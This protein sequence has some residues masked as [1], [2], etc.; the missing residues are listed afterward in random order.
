FFVPYS[1]PYIIKLILLLAVLALFGYGVYRLFRMERNFTVAV[2]VYELLFLVAKGY[3]DTTRPDIEFRRIFSGLWI[4]YLICFIGGYF[5]LA[6]I[7]HRQKIKTADFVTGGG[8]LLVLSVSLGIPGL[9]I[10]ALVL[11]LV[12][13]VFTAFKDI[14]FSRKL[15]YPAVLIL[16]IFIGQVFYFSY[17]KSKEY[18]VSMAPKAAYAAAQWLNLARIKRGA[19]ILSY[20]DNVMMNFYLD[21]NKEGLQEI[22][23][24]TFTVPLIIN[25]ETKAHYIQAFF[26]EIRE[27]K[28]DYIIF[29][30]YVVPKPEFTGVNQAKRMLYEERENK[31]YF[32]LKQ[33]LFYKGEN[34]G[35]VLKPVNAETN[36]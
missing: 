9:P 5:F 25:P 28:V 14:P 6:K 35:Y 30:N 36:H 4:F 18:V 12:P 22:H 34:V 31:N 16:M 11:L 10:V 29:D 23:W 33:N 8:L 19:T 3:V 2:M 1:Y 32:R 7:Y 24:E 20:T 21:K 26:K 13:A 15:K 17:C 27:R